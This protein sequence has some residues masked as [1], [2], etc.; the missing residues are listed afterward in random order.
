[1]QLEFS[2]FYCLDDLPVPLP[3]FFLKG[4]MSGLRIS[5]GITF[6]LEDFDTLCDDLFM[7]SFLISSL[8]CVYLFKNSCIPF[9]FLS[10]SLCHSICFFKEPALTHV[11]SQF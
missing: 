6:A 5:P 10:M 11:W 4:G 8:C 2:F 7:E 1:M 9:S 3:M